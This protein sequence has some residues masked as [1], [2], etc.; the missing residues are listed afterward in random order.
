MDKKFEEL[1]K[2]FVGIATESVNKAILVERSI[3]FAEKHNTFGACGRY[4]SAIKQMFE[5]LERAY[6][7]VEEIEEQCSK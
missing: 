6:E 1:Q 7:L 2:I 4:K 5:S 3:Y